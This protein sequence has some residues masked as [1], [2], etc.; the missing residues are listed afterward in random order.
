MY[1]DHC[2]KSVAENLVQLLFHCDNVKAFL[3][4]TIMIHRSYANNTIVRWLG[5]ELIRS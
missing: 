3:T 1:L 4:A 5:S 2:P